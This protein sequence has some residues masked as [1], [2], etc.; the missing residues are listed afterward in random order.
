MQGSRGIGKGFGGFDQN[1]MV[2]LMFS[3]GDCH[4]EKTRLC[5]AKRKSREIS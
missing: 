4:W 2:C 3:E 5:G 1:D